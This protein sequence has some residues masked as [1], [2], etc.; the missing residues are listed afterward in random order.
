MG[1]EVRATAAPCSACG[2]VAEPDDGPTFDRV[3]TPGQV[4]LCIA[5][6]ALGVVESIQ[7][8]AFG[9]HLIVRAPSPAEHA[10]MLADPYIVHMIE[11][12]ARMARRVPDWPTGPTGGEQRKDEP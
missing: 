4:T 8:D 5:C 9:L 11:M 2:W 10:A 3:P 7:G 6:G 12:R 1:D